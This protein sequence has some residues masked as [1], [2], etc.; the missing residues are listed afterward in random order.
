MQKYFARNYCKE[1][2]NLDIGRQIK[3]KRRIF[4]LDFLGGRCTNCGE[5][6]YMVMNI[7][8][9]KNDSAKDRKGGSGNVTIIVYNMIRKGINIKKIFQLL[10]ANC[11]IKKRLI[12]DELQRLI[13]LGLP[14]F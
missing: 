8:H 3:T 4:V 9:I 11:N 12:H 14:S 6:D 7:D 2:Y 5:T 13:R 10:C 1:H